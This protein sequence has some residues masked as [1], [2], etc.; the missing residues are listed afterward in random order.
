M[1]PMTYYQ[2]FPLSFNIPLLVPYYLCIH[3]CLR[4]IQRPISSYLF[5]MLNLPSNLEYLHVS[6]TFQGYLTSP[7]TKNT[8]AVVTSDLIT[9]LLNLT[10]FISPPFSSQGFV[11]PFFLIHPM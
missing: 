4:L 10:L 11:V 1:E 2:L 9:S 8:L 3:L 5:L 7:L 6:L